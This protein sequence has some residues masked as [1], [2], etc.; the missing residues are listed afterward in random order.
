MPVDASNL[1]WR[2]YKSL[3][4]EAS[5]RVVINIVGGFLWEQIRKIYKRWKKLVSLKSNYV[6]MKD[7]RTAGPDTKKN[8]INTYNNAEIQKIKYK[9][10]VRHMIFFLNSLKIYLHSDTKYV[11][12]KINIFNFKKLQGRVSQCIC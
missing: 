10:V 8:N 5:H 1:K 2:W 3:K 4:K 12:R 11:H 7:I 6:K 9:S